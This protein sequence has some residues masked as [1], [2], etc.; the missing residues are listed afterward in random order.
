VANIK[1][2]DP[3]WVIIIISLISLFVA[4]ITFGILQST[5]VAKDERIQLGGAAAGFV[6][7]FALI[8]YA[9]NLQMDKKRKTEKEI[10]IEE[11]RIKEQNDTESM[12]R[13][14]FLFP[15]GYEA[16]FMQES[17]NGKYKILENGKL[18]GSGDVS[19]RLEHEWIW[20]PPKI[21][22]KQDYSIE[23]ELE[24]DNH[25]KWKTK[26]FPVITSKPIEMP[27]K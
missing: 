12:Y 2:I 21:R 9:Y 26:I 6:A 4:Y 14:N 15:D 25:K 23:L 10:R 24:D 27:K 22:I 16:N 1:E 3:L 5:G 11:I 13:I 18:I 8:N 19:L 20:K 7:V 17:V